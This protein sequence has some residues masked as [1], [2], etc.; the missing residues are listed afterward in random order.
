MDYLFSELNDS[1]ET[2]TLEVAVNNEAAINLYKKFGFE[3]IHIRKKYYNGI[4]AYLMGRR[5]DK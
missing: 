1:V 4:D 5:I 2:V 3:I